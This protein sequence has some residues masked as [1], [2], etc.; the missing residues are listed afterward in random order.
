[1]TDLEAQDHRFCPQ[2]FE[3]FPLPAHACPEHRCDL[4]RLRYPEGSLK[5]RLIDGKYVILD[6]LGRGGMGVVYRARQMPIKREVAFKVLNREFL[7]HPASVKRFIREASAAS[8]LRSRFSAIVH[9][10]G[11]AREGFLYFTMELARGNLLSDALQGHTPL[12]VEQACLV[13]MDICRSLEEA[14]GFGIVHRDLKPGNIMLLHGED[15]ILAKV[16][17]FGTARLIEA[18][19]ADRI[20]DPGKVFGTPEY[21]SPE[22]AMGEDV[23]PTADLYSLGVMLYEMVTG[24]LPFTGK[25]HTHLLLKQIRETPRSLRVVVPEREIPTS[26]DELVAALLKKDPKRRPATARE[27][28]GILSAILHEHFPDAWEPSPTV[29]SPTRPV[30]AAPSG[31][32][33]GPSTLPSFGAL[34]PEMLQEEGTGEDGLRRTLALGTL[35][36]AEDD[37][38]GIPG[39]VP[40][41]IQAADPLL[42]KRAPRDEGPDAAQGGSPGSRRLLPAAAL[43]LLFGVL[44][45]GGWRVSQFIMEDRAQVSPKTTTQEEAEQPSAAPEAGP[46]ARRAPPVSAAIPAPSHAVTPAPDAT[47]E[48]PGRPTPATTAPRLHRTSAGRHLPIG[49]SGPNLEGFFFRQTR[50]AAAPEGDHRAPD[51]EAPDI[52]TAEDVVAAPEEDTPPPR[53]HRPRTEEADGPGRSRLL[54][55]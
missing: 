16:L 7:K 12:D 44:I 25:T 2:C 9:D 33:P 1:M 36:G 52:R 49:P 41:A 28:R 24:D 26:L 48:S 46:E 8:M 32:T 15:R 19:G 47:A 50:A 31:S 43:L 53:D 5:G 27:V 38:D 29:T 20:T 42:R 45:A 35:S 51:S 6:L 54:H 3:A 10:F 14:H 18:R 17:D 4:V 30:N 34:T 37:E 13:A 39:F 40:A 11:L 21:M 22:Q 23:G 55:G